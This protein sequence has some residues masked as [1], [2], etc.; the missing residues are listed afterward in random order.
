MASHPS[1]T[2]NGAKKFISRVIKSEKDK[3]TKKDKALAIAL[4][5]A[6]KE[7]GANIPKPKVN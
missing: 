7:K 5:R 3:G 2:H 1:N 4:N 6:R